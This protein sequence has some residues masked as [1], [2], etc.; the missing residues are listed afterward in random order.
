MGE[1]YLCFQA[2]HLHKRTALLLK[3]FKCPQTT[4]NQ[5]SPTVESG[6]DLFP[7]HF[8][9]SP[10]VLQTPKQAVRIPWGQHILYGSPISQQRSRFRTPGLRWAAGIPSDPGCN[11]TP[12]LALYLAD[13]VCFS[14]LMLKPGSRMVQN[15]QFA[16]IRYF[17][18]ATKRIHAP[19]LYR[20]ESRDISH[21]TQTAGCCP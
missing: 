10:Q 7:L 19:D 21:S 13:V 9:P 2:A 11:E 6:D 17:P 4:V 12:H 8:L 5:W 16:V 20:Q 15:K 1:L 18:Y 14:P 3:M